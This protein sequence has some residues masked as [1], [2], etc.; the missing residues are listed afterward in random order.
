MRPAPV[1][2]PIS[3]VSPS[4]VPVVSTAEVPLRSIVPELAVVLPAV[5]NE[6]RVSAPPICNVVKR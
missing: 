1:M 3:V 5:T 4:V 6:F 2:R